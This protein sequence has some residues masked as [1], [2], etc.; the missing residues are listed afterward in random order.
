VDKGG[1][2][3]VFLVCKPAS[4]GELVPIA[5]T[6]MT[7][8]RRLHK[9]RVS[10]NIEEYRASSISKFRHTR[11]ETHRPRRGLNHCRNVMVGLHL[12]VESSALSQS[13]HSS[14][15]LSPSDHP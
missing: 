3:D 10:A 13:V 2:I 15:R 6:G 14:L 7:A 9:K 8:P 1:Y 12:P 11:T 5:G 4:L